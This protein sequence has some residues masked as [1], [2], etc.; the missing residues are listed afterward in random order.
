M[1]KDGDDP[2]CFWKR[3]F[4]GKPQ[5]GNFSYIWKLNDDIPMFFLD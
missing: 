3:E 5:I 2:K 4:S 1:P